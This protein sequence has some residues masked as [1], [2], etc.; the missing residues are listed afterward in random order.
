MRQ[1]LTSLGFE[2]VDFYPRFSRIADVEVSFK[3]R[4]QIDLVWVPC[5]RQRDLAAAVRWGRRRKV[6]VVFDPL[7]SAYDKQVF[8]R[9]KFSP[10]SASARRLLKWERK[11][12]SLVDLLLAD[13]REHAHYFAEELAV[14]DS[15][16]AVVP[17]G[18]DEELFVLGRQDCCLSEPPCVLFYGSFL[19]LQGPEF[20]VEAAR[21]YKGPPVVWKLVG[22]G[23]LLNECRSRAADLPNVE[24]VPWI[25]YEELP[26]YIY[27]ADIVLGIFGTSAKASRVIPN[28]VYQALA[29]GKPLVTRY[30]RAYPT[31]FAGNNTLGIGW[32]E[33]GNPQQLADKIAEWVAA[34][35]QLPAIGQQARLT[36]ESHF[37]MASISAKLSNALEPLL[38]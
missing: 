36:Y 20:I 38:S 24:F 27:Q 2:L 32:V 37:S 5:F 11:L 33:P 18:A 15:R 7:I 23:P 22:E 30:A 34:R 26:A 16:V 17:V 3:L 14:S 9:K 21:L 25:A 12:F 19:N 35:D 29:C 10:G 28:K 8:E 31:E 6:P 1:C 4:G 13:T